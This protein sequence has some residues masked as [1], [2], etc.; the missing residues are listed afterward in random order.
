MN[1][2]ELNK[3]FACLNLF[4]NLLIT[5]PL[6][7]LMHIRVIFLAVYYLVR[8]L[9]LQCVLFRTRF[10]VC[11][12]CCWFIASLWVGQSFWATP[13]AELSLWFVINMSQ[14]ARLWSY[15]YAGVR[16][17]QEICRLIGSATGQGGGGK[18][19]GRIDWLAE[20]YLLSLETDVGHAVPRANRKRPPI[21]QQA[22]VMANGC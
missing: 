4:F 6:S 18:G 16:G 8:L 19:G 20:F 22:L 14:L 10:S 11:S 3:F 5:F 21:V 2:N 7:N 13:A 17:W 12:V 15:S 1:L 9:V